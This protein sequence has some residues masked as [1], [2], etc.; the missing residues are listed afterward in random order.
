MLSLTDLEE[1]GSQIRRRL[2]EWEGQAS[3]LRSKEVT[4]KDD[5]STHRQQEELHE[6]ALS[7]LQELEGTWRGKYEAALAALG[8]QGLSSIWGDDRQVVLDSTIKR[9]VANLDVA[10]VKGGERVRLKGG[11]G[12]SVVQVLASI[13]R[14]LTALS[15]P[16]WRLLFVLDEP[17]SMVATQQ[18]PALCEL[19]RGLQQ[20]LGFQ[21]IFSSHE[22]ELLEAADTAYFIRGDGQGTADQLKTLEKEE[23]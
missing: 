9:G 15:N 8:S 11:S 22:D 21:L 19:V 10:L 1:L 12:G 5:E 14:V 18:R 17:F 3:L 2:H 16:N 23:S 13:L 4:L 20:R 6:K 7:I